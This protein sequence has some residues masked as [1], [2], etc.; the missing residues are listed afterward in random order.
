VD[1]HQTDGAT[2][3]TS[4]PVGAVYSTQALNQPVQEAES[5]A[6][7]IITKNLH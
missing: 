7:A 6:E 3:G 4:T 5:A 2:L 1:T